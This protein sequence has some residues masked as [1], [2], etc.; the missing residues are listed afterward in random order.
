[1][2]LIRGLYISATGLNAG[3]KRQDVISNNLAN[4]S[5]AGFKRETTLFQSLLEREIYHYP[6][7]QR[8]EYLGQLG[9][10]TNFRLGA[11]D[12]SMGMVLG[13]GRNLD[14][15]IGNPDAW[16]TV[17]HNGGQAYTRNGQLMVDGQGYLKTTSGAYILDAQGNRIQVPSDNISIQG[18]GS[19]LDDAGDTLGR[20]GVATFDPEAQLTRLGD[21]LWQSDLPVIE[22]QDPQL[23][24]GALEQANVQVIKEMVNLISAMRAYETNTKLIQI[25]DET[26]NKAVNE[27]GRV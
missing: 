27:V 17:E 4:A 24:Q 5:T 7:A 12:F 15:L 14:V 16:L 8:P 26:L 18:D 6:P 2:S 25:Q 19:L 10:G 1:M 9:T 23:M 13:T 21:A 3:I 22:A 20:L 11:N